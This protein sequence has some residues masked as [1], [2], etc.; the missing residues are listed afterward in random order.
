[1]TAESPPP[2][3]ARL[4]HPAFS[5]HPAALPLA[6]A[7]LTDRQKMALLLEAAGL[8]SLLARAGW[9][10]PLGW[11]GARVVPG[12]RLSVPAPVPGR[13]H[14][15]A[16]GFPGTDA[17]LPDL[18]AALF[19]PEPIAGRGEARRS[20]RVLKLSLARSF[21]PLSPDAVVA[22][23]LEA[24]PFLWQPMFGP[25]RRSLVGEL[26]RSDGTVLP[27]VA[28]PA[29]LRRRLLT[30]GEDAGSL[31]A[32]L[33]GPAARAL[34]D[35]EEE[36]DPV[37]LA[38]ASKWRAAVAAWQHRPP[39]SPD[40]RLAYARC[41]WALGRFEGALAAL[42]GL[43]SPAARVLALRCQL[44]LGRLD[45][46]RAALSR[47]GPRLPAAE[48]AEAADV[49]VRAFANAGARDKAW[50]WVERAL[51]AGDTEGKAALPHLVAA[52]FAWDRSDAE[53]MERHLEAAKDA[54]T[55]PELAW[56]WH[57]ARGLAAL[58]GD[59]A[60]TAVSHLGRAI[61][62]SRR[63]LPRHQAA[64][65]WND[66]GLGRALTGDLPGAERAFLH[67]FR[68]FGSCDGPRK[69]TLALSNL[70]EI[71]IRR[72]RLAGVREI[73]ERVTEENRRSRNLRGLAQ[74]HALWARFELALGRPEA[75]LALC[76]R[77][78][79]E[80]GGQGQDWHRAE[81]ATF[82]LRSLGWLGRPEEGRDL[83]VEDI[84]AATRELEAEERPAFWALLGDGERAAA[85][86]ERQGPADAWVP[87]WRAALAGDPADPGSF[88]A[89]AGLEP[90]RRAR[91]LFDLEMAAA[92]LVPS[93]LLRQAADTLRRS[94]AVPLAGRL[95]ERLEGPW[96][97]LA[98]Y[99]S[100]EAAGWDLAPLAEAMS[101]AGHPD[102]ELSWLAAPPPPPL[103]GR[104]QR[105]AEVDGGVLRLTAPRIGPALEA[106]FALAVREAAGPRVSPEPPRTPSAGGAGRAS[107]DMVG[108]SPA[109]VAARERIDRLAP[110]EIPVLI[111]G[112]SGTGKELAARRLHRGSPRA[113]G[114]FLPVNCAALSETL[115]LSDLFGHSRGA[116]TGADRERAGVFETAH[117]GTVFLDEIGDLPPTAQGMLLRVLQ[118]GEVRR[119]GDSM[120]RRVDVR[121]LAATHRDL[122]EMVEEGTFRRDL[123][124]RLR[125]GSVRLPALRERGDD[126]VLLGEAFLQKGLQHRGAG[127]TAPAWTAL[128]RHD[129]P[130]NVRELEN[131][132]LLADALAGGD[133]VRPEHLDLPRISTDKA[134]SYARQ[135][136]ALR[137]R[138]VVEAL[139]ASGGNRAE[140]ARRLGISRQ[141]LSYLVR[142]LG[143]S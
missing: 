105:T 1:M 26:H 117:G 121:V 87:L 81:L 96:R 88:L 143:L 123:Y 132:L 27:W 7:R 51:A 109:F 126:L 50:A 84:A 24:A 39:A 68:L 42:Q 107:G 2:R 36:G 3:Y 74:D 62:R 29:P 69:T 43:A 20:A 71:R 103:P 142:Q 82:A 79:A 40:E 28:G 124:Y 70:A 53:A 78:L 34:W 60:A 76:R 100:R 5:P 98:G 9:S 54:L 47:P 12:G 101:R 102:A 133:L 21:V 35:R 127:I 48:A 61:H 112:E 75:A 141:A 85:E 65:L 46:V 94:G 41:L 86:L 130:G 33:A 63:F 139:E 91:L 52:G 99:L 10:L 64:A 14:F 73:L 97:V 30:A 137:R 138:L 66:F 18:L 116:F 25:A 113:R 122:V 56:R 119:L 134:G 93:D 95:E 129:W 92:G 13:V 125:V 38:Q 22:A 58:Q 90:Y 140:A 80:L 44:L 31:A 59:D 83:L 15:G 37:A 55:V 106:F 57:Q 131:V 49:A 110:A 115:T 17:S 118:E 77:A 11:D 4:V 67:S 72:G 114:P 6:A 104:E 89:L 45:A 111:L 8:L 120:P 16:A 136:D 108:E 32:A 135:V 128:R 23:V 19:G